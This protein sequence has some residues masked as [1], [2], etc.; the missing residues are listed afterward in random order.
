ML[1][2]DEVLLRQR[3]DLVLFDASPLSVGE[4]PRAHLDVLVVLDDGVLPV[5]GLLCQRG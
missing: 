3:I 1:S 5:L 4:P 2:T